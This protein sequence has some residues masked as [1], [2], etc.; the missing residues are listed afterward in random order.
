MPITVDYTP[1]GALGQ[2]AV[3]AGKNQAAQQSLM[4]AIRLREMANQERAQRAQESAHLLQFVLQQKSMQEQAR[5]FDLSRQ[6]QQAQ[7]VATSGARSASIRA[8]REQAD[9]AFALQQAMLAQR[10]RERLAAL[11]NQRSPEELARLRLDTL[12]K[13]EEI[14]DQYKPKPMT[15]QEK[16]TEAALRED[17]LQQVRQQYKPAP[18]PPRP[19]AMPGVKETPE[20]KMM[21][22]QLSALDR[23]AH[24]LQQQIT[25]WSAFEKTDELSESIANNKNRLQRIAAEKEKLEADLLAKRQAVYGP[26]AAARSE[27]NK[28]AYSPTI[29]GGTQPPKGPVGEQNSPSNLVT[30]IK[31]EFAQKNQGLPP[32]PIIIAEIYKRYDTAGMPRPTKDELRMILQAGGIEVK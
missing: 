20:T 32:T 11:A 28:R 22:G 9:Q 16:L 3:Q 14:K 13:E 6:D 18:T 17:V 5:R 1:V 21:A 25:M 7:F 19:M 30:E 26:E 8:S 24:D 31:N 15:A 27:F 2:L 29:P 10:E 23:E 4:N 12:A